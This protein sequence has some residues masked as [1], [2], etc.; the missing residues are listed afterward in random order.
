MKSIGEVK[1]FFGWILLMRLQ[2]QVIADECHPCSCKCDTGYAS[3]CVNCEDLQ[4][5]S[6]PSFSPNLTK[7]I[8][9]LILSYNHLTTVGNNDFIHLTN[10]EVLELTD[11][12]ISTIGERSFA[13][14]EKLK[15]VKLEYNNLLNISLNDFTGLRSL[16]EV[17]L[18]NNNI[19]TID[20]NAFRY[21]SKLEILSLYGNKISDLNP[22]IFTGLHELKKLFLD[23]N[24]IRRLNRNSFKSLFQLEFLSL[25]NNMITTL[26]E[27]FNDLLSLKTLQLQKNNLNF[28]PAALWLPSLSGLELSIY[29]N[30]FPCSCL[31]INQMKQLAHRVGRLKPSPYSFAKCLNVSSSCED[32]RNFALGMNVAGSRCLKTYTEPLENAIDGNLDSYGVCKRSFSLSNKPYLL[33]DLP[34]II[35]VTRVFMT[36][37][38]ES[39]YEIRYHDFKTGNVTVEAGDQL[40]KRYSI[41]YS[42]TRSTTNITTFNESCAKYPEG[43]NVKVSF[44][45]DWYIKNILIYEVIVNGYEKSMYNLWGEWNEW[46][47]CSK[48]CG[49]GLSRR[50]RTCNKSTAVKCLLEGLRKENERGLIELSLKKCHLEPCSDSRVMYQ[51][52]IGS[53][54]GV[55]VLTV[56][57]I[58]F[59]Y[60]KFK[61]I[62][63]FDGLYPNANFELD[64]NRALLE[65]IEELPYDLHW[66]FPR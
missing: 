15:I 62:T 27:P 58:V 66:E 36:M 64:S 22:H 63:Y 28:I 53:I 43:R 3:P 23:R 9:S 44:E 18:D 42:H 10:L 61:M 31:S 52:I 48:T 11:N 41:C 7:T 45:N 47:P 33:I 19:V 4:L 13:P 5:T 65:Q 8:R 46:S 56:F 6:F 29:G 26:D 35:I 38:Y 57:G 20:G 30:Q 40:S 32:E 49:I 17:W 37:Q 60:R 1:V 50:N 51:W 2:L 24:K 14:L 55:F 54:A 21:L 34:G 39:E 25:S 59:W 12:H 16:K